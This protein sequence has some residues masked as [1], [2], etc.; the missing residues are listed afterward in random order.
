M[1]C[2]WCTPRLFPWEIWRRSRL[3]GAYPLPL[4]EVAERSEDGE[5]NMTILTSQ[6]ENARR[7]RREMMPH[8]RKLW[9]L[10]L[11]KYPAKIYKQRIIGRFIVDFYCRFLLC[12]CTIGHWSGWLPTLG[13]SGVGRWFWAICILRSTW[14]GGFAF[15]QPGDRQ[16]F[17]RCVRTNWH[18]HSKST[19]TPSQSPAVTA[20]PKGEPR[21]SKKLSG[22]WAF[23]YV[24]GTI[25]LGDAR[26]W[27]VEKW[28]GEYL[29]S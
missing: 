12:I 7:L 28:N 10:F 16:S 22:S 26:C 15:F 19:A 2:V 4:G 17:L 13:T 5:G 25:Y 27:N 14:L 20:L 18:G 24:C 1:W 23:S 8:E 6:L 3:R 29:R 11:R 21:L 9:Y